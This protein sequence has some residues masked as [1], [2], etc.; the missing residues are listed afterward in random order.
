MTDYDFLIK[1]KEEDTDFDVK[2]TPYKSD[3][4]FDFLKDI[5]AMANADIETD[6]HI[7]IG[8]SI[9]PRQR[10]LLGMD[11]QDFRDSA[12][13]VDL[14][15]DYIEP[16]INFKYFPYD[17][18][19]KTF[20][21]IEI[22]N[23]NKPPYM[24]KKDFQRKLQRDVNDKK[25]D[26]LLNGEAWIRNGSSQDRM[27]RNDFEQI[28]EKKFKKR[29]FVGEIKLFFTDTNSEILH[30]STLDDLILPSKREY[31]LITKIIE[32]KKKH[33]ENEPKSVKK[34]HETI[35][36]L[37]ERFRSPSGKYLTKDIPELEKIRDKI[38]EEYSEDD[39]YEIF[40]FRGNR[41]NIT[42]ENLGNE[43]LEDASIK[44]VIP[45]IEGLAIADRE[46]HKPKRNDNL[47]LPNPFNYY[48]KSLSFYPNVLYS[49]D[50]IEIT[51]DI[52]DIKHH[53]PKEIFS[54]PL[55]IVLNKSLAGKTIEIQ[56]YIYGKNLREPRF[57]KLVIQGTESY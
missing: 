48:F 8:V 22:S 57:K 34:S 26:I 35:R 20:G 4:Y 11:R 47:I 2:K 50:K 29:G 36:S 44:L 30:L 6:R 51:I 7:V 40:G 23:C 25:P 24:M 10:N 3:T 41:V 45:K 54:N 12:N 5:M 27:K 9:E 55:R 32:E 53:I 52:G 39:Y 13:Y 42:I 17:Y 14:L 18:D 56:C 38:K 19:G 1:E 21:I 16:D 28:Y 43:Y 37:F 31:D 49:Y 46:P 33:N 15:R